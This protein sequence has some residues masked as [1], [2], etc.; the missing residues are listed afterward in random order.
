MP[1]EDGHDPSGTSVLAAA[2]NVL[3]RLPGSAR[4][5]V[6]VSGGSDSTGLLHALHR[7]RLACGRSDISLFA[8]T[9]D[10]GLRRESADEAKAVAALCAGFGIPHLT[11]RWQGDK[12]STGISAAARS[13]RYAL[14]SSLADDIQADAILTGHTLDD[15]WETLVMRASRAGAEG[16][17][18]ADGRVGAAGMAPAVLLFGRH[19]LLRPFLR[20]RRQTIRQSLAAADLGWFDDPSNSDL[21]FERA[22]TRL[23][24]ADAASL[25]S[26]DELDRLALQRLALG[27]TVAAWLG[28]G[29][30]V[31]GGVLARL[32]PARLADVDDTVLTAACA[33]L[34]AVFGG[35]VHPPGRDSLGRIV[36]FLRAGEPGRITAG[37]VLFDRR[38]AD[39]FILR[40]NRDLP[41]LCLAAGESAEWDGRF[42][43]H[44]VGSA[45]LVVGPYPADRALA[46]SRFQGV[47]ASLALTALQALP[48]LQGVGQE[49]DLRSLAILQPYRSF[50]PAF[51]L[52]LANSF[53]VRL[54]LQAFPPL[55][56][57][58]FDRKT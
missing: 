39:L 35:R 28:E 46:L 27:R 30:A 55:P 19:W 21:R 49:A 36:A 15:Q 43:L 2:C 31:S 54:G 40:E 45:P 53:A 6:A 14:L 29:L 47:P 26:P 23:R 34:I 42:L 38:R 41:T 20:L 33:A 9:I 24:L 57:N 3:T 58:V 56:F 4:L 5:L 22:R 10:H 12:P 17:P 32:D 11:R 48:G 7:G 8:A 25:P 37:R 44:N 13:A 18:G 51:E 16:Q 1:S 52:D 50:L